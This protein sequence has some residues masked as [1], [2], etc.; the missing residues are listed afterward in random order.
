[1][2]YSLTEL[3]SVIMWDNGTMINNN[4]CCGFSINNKL[5]SALASTMYQGYPNSVSVSDP[6]E[7]EHEFS[8]WP[9][10]CTMNINSKYVQY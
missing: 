10:R 5:P 3:Y 2:Q 8:S 9:L 1:M 4:E 6:V 7:G